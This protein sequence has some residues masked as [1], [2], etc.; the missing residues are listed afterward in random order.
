MTDVDRALVGSF[1]DI[2]NKWRL[3]S[4]VIQE[5]EDP[6][7]SDIV[8]VE[9]LDAIES[10][11]DAMVALLTADDN[12]QYLSPSLTGVT[13]EMSIYPW[14][15]DDPQKNRRMRAAAFGTLAHEIWKALKNP[16]EDVVRTGSFYATLLG[17]VIAVI[18]L[19]V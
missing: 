3:S 15:K 17:L 18:T 1:L 2:G 4:G 10:A 6:T 11:E 13:K 5:I 7:N 9:H 16:P 8:P 12:A 14:D 19:F